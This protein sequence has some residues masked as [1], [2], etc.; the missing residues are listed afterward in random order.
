VFG[1]VKP[2]FLFVVVWD[3]GGPAT[4]GKK[5]Q[6]QRVGNFHEKNLSKPKR[7]PVPTKELCNFCTCKSH[8]GATVCP[9]RTK[10]VNSTAAMS[11]REALQQ[12][13]E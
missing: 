8:G 5:R 7:Y 12:L 6:R 13:C 3:A 10:W 2:L 9:E 11:E 4:R 1:G